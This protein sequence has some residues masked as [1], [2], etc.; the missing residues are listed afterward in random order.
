M[1]LQKGNNKKR[2]EPKFCEYIVLYGTFYA[3]RKPL[4]GHLAYTHREYCNF[5]I[6][7]NPQYKIVF[8]LLGL[9]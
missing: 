8:L 3:T 6:W 9:I 4:K 5:I 7:L 1:I 2:K